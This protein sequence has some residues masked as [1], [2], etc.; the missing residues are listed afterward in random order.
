MIDTN[1][2]VSIGLQATLNSWGARPYALPPSIDEATGFFDDTPPK[3]VDTV[4][5]G[6]ESDPEAWQTVPVNP[7]AIN[8]PMLPRYFIDGKLG[9]HLVGGGRDS[10]GVPRPILAGQIGVGYLSL[11]GER[12][13]NTSRVLIM[14]L[15]GV[16]TAEEKTIRTE[17][18]N[19]PIGGY[20]FLPYRPG[21]GTAFDDRNFEAVHQLMYRRGRDEMIRWERNMTEELDRPIYVDGRVRDHLSLGRTQ[22]VV[23]VIK[24]MYTAYLHSRGYEV[25][26]ALGPGERTPAALLY[27]DG[28]DSPA[29][30]TFYMRL[31][32]ESFNP[33]RGIVRVELRQDA[34]ETLAEG[35]FEYLD[36]LAAHLFS[37]RCQRPD[38]GRAHVTTEP[39]YEVEQIIGACFVQA[40]LV[41]LEVQSFLF[42]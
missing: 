13:V 42:S 27:P 41:A 39:I 28:F 4:K 22:L 30:V 9:L 7:S 11:D 17:L 29:V 26:D 24:R 3:P 1:S 25:R 6:Y 35:S 10:D 19:A 36:A 8:N 12:D 15:A 21:Y 20:S 34:F 31:S 16:S 40:S 5:L 37:L 23:G 32:D 2:I 14:N 38:Y 33:T 18:E